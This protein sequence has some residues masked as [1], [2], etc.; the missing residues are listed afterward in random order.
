MG[1]VGAIAVIGY[2]EFGIGV[3][4]RDC[5]LSL[6]SETEIMIGTNLFQA[7]FARKFSGNPETIVISKLREGTYTVYVRAWSDPIKPSI[8]ETGATITVTGSDGSIVQSIS[9]SSATGN[10]DY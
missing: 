5:S 9:A 4:S 3:F 6:S 10:G 1:M 8:P 7:P 2:D